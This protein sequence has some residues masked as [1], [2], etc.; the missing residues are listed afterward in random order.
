MSILRGLATTFGVLTLVAALVLFAARWVPVVNHPVLVA[1]LVAPLALLA[2]PVSVVLFAIAR[3]GLATAGAVATLVIVS[4]QLPAFVAASPPASAPTIRMMSLNMCLGQADPAAVVAVALRDA[5]VLAVQELT[6]A[7]AAR[8][9]AAGLDATFPHRL[10]DPRA[11]ASGIGLWSRYPLSDTGHLDGYHM[12]AL[13]ARVDLLGPG[14]DPVVAVLRHGRALA[15]AG[16]RLARRHGALTDD[17]RAPR[18]RGRRRRGARGGRLQ[19]HNRHETVPPRA[20][21]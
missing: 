10:I 1:A 18:R 17:A 9:S 20:D 7:V 16:G 13:M 6:P 2:A 8:L 15:A 19:Q 11:E 4:A 5:D 12:P 3:A 14:P 21:G